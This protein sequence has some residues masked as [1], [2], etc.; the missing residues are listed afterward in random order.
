M[1]TEV[2]LAD[3]DYVL[4]DGAGW[5]DVDGFAIRIHRTAE[6]VIA[7]IFDNKLLSDGDIDDSLMATACAFTADLSENQPEE[8]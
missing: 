7:D 2:K 6:G 1:E 5:F 3:A 4:T 8:N